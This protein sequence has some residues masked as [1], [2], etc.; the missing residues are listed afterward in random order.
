MGFAGNKHSRDSSLNGS[1]LEQGAVAMKKAAK[2]SSGRVPEPGNAAKQSHVP[3]ST[4]LTA[5]GKQQA[6]KVSRS[7]RQSRAAQRARRNAAEHGSPA[8]GKVKS[9]EQAFRTQNGQAA[10]PVMSSGNMTQ[11]VDTPAGTNFSPRGKRNKN[12]FRPDAEQ[13]LAAEVP[14][15]SSLEGSGQGALPPASNSQQTDASKP[16]QAAPGAS[17]AADKKRKNKNKFK[18]EGQVSAAEQNVDM[19]PHAP[20]Q[21]AAAPQHAGQQ[22]LPGHQQQ[23]GK[24]KANNHVQRIKAE[25]QPVQAHKSSHAGSE[26]AAAGKQGKRSKQEL[27]SGYGVPPAVA[28]K[29]AVKTVTAAPM[30][31]VTLVSFDKAKFLTVSCLLMRSWVLAEMFCPICINII[32]WLHGLQ[33]SVTCAGTAVSANWAVLKAQ[34]VPAGGRKRQRP[35]TEPE[36]APKAPEPLADTQGVTPV[37]A[38]DCE[39]VGVG[40]EGKRSTLARCETFQDLLPKLQQSSCQHHMQLPAARPST[41]LQWWVLSC[42]L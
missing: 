30:S 25:P 32:K 18:Q 23:E 13:S 22:G 35:T 33:L 31:G 42:E 3:G 40:P 39:M 29:A 17:A 5:D 12:K 6:V 4:R 14:E 41:P 26:Q 16:S 19:P 8:G 1:K 27:P 10:D 38:V 15:Q 11:P 37:L 7:Q 20:K 9:S 2:T 36:A 28:T 24:G 34:I 21:G